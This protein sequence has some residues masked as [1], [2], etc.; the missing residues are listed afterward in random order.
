MC[1]R[2]LEQNPKTLRNPGEHNL[3][4]KEVRIKT[5]DNMLLHG[6]FVFQPNSHLSKT[7]VYF[8]ENAGSN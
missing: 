6:W 8:H 2:D 7:L 4:Y 1:T 3:P 5:R